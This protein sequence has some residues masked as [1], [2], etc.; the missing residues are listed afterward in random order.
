MQHFT[1]SALSLHSAKKG[2][3]QMRS[4]TEVVSFKA[5][6]R[7]VPP[8][9]ATKFTIRNCCGARDTEPVSSLPKR[10]GQEFLNDWWPNRTANQAS[11]RS[12]V[13]PF[14]RILGSQD[15]CRRPTTRNLFLRSLLEPLFPPRRR[16]FVEKKNRKKERKQSRPAVWLGTVDFAWSSG[17]KKKKKGIPRGILRSRTNRLGEN[18]GKKW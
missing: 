10:L 18:Y 16:N 1:R 7:T 14:R 13:C 11:L 9:R 6:P 5:Q 15:S 4:S 2:E 12:Y 17:K 8:M 3:N